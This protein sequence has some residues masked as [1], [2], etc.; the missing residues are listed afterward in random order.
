LEITGNTL[1]D[2]HDFHDDVKIVHF[3]RSTNKPHEWTEY[4]RFN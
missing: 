4:D 2:G 1:Y 3:T